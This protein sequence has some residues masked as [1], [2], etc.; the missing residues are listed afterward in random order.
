MPQI[1]NVRTLFTFYDVKHRGVEGSLAQCLTY[2]LLDSAALG[3]I[4]SIPKKFQSN[5]IVDV[6][7]VNQQLRLEE[8]GQ[9]LKHLDR[10]HL[11]LASSNQ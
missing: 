3:L 8:S 9:W 6:A 1:Y 4:L 7:E 5:K 10:T 11:E 2:L